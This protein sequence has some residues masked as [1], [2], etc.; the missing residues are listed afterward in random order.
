MF[1]STLHS[2]E[3]L[4]KNAHFQ[5]WSADREYYRVTCRPGWGVLCMLQGTLR[6]RFDGS[7]LDAKPGDVLLLPPGCS[8][9]VLFVDGNAVDYLINFSLPEGEVLTPDQRPTFLLN[10][11]TGTVA[12]AFRAV[13]EAY[14]GGNA[15]YLLR[16]LFYRCMHTLS[17]A[18]T[19]DG[20]TLSQAAKLL[21]DHPELPITE[22]AMQ[23]HMSRSLFQ[24]RFRQVYGM[25]PVDYRN[26]GRIQTAKLLLETTELPIKQIADQLGFYD[27]AYFY[28]VFR[29][30]TGT[31]PKDYRSTSHPLL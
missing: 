28:K 20:F 4:F 27:V 23:L 29:S 15:P 6:Y 26:H 10:D 12:A 5:Q 16:E 25:S 8:Y 3:L 31:T 2:G 9:D 30:L 14:R 21:C 11:P 17:T 19:Q 13:V 22:V 24:K 18:P 7:T 1:D